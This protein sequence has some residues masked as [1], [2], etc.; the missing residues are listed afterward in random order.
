MTAP[1]PFEP[2]DLATLE[3]TTKRYE[4]LGFE[5]SLGVTHPAEGRAA[6]W[7]V[8]PRNRPS[9]TFQLEIEKYFGR[10][11]S[12]TWV[13][14]IARSNGFTMTMRSV[15]QVSSNILLFALTK[16]ELVISERKDSGHHIPPDEQEDLVNASRAELAS[17]NKIAAAV[18]MVAPLSRPTHQ[19]IASGPSR[20]ISAREGQSSFGIDSRTR[21]PTTVPRRR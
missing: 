5:A 18:R 1:A 20:P 13:I 15:G 11:G 7:Y 4:A 19:A 21:G 9:D 10:F 3:R 6:I 17:L 12:V 16:A 2:R 8:D 14:R